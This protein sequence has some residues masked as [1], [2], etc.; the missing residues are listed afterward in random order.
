MANLAFTLSALLMVPF[1]AWGIYTLR[2]RYVLHEEIPRHVEV[3]T[4]CGVVIFGIVQLLLSRQ[5]MGRIEILYVFTVLSLLVASTALYGPIFIS[6]ASQAVVDFLHPHREAQSHTPHFGPAQALEENGD[7]EGALREYMVMARI[8]PKH[9]ETSLRTG[10]AF[11]GLGRYEEAVEALERGLAL[12]KEPERALIVTN[13]LSDI[14]LRQLE[15]EEDAVRVL[16]SY[17]D[18]HP[19]GKRVESVKK[20]LERISNA[21]ASEP[22]G[23]VNGLPNSPQVEPWE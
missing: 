23:P 17:L 10:N 19:E 7:L 11:A 8:F 15:R 4:L 9:P 16:T 18:R 1:F 21:S 13:R 22:G 5:W 14:Y 6:V 20:K 12:L 2:E 3:A